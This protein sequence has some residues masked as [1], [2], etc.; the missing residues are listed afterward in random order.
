MFLLSIV[1]FIISKILKKKACKIQNTN[2]IQRGK[3]TYKDLD[4]PGKVF[5]S[6]KYKIAGKPDYIVKQKN[7]F[8]PVELKSTNSTEPRQNHILQLAAYCQLI[9]EKYG[10]FV[11][12]GIL[13]YN[14]TQQYS[15]PFDPKTRFELESTIKEMRN[16]LKTGK[17]ALNHDQMNRCMNCSMQKYCDNKIC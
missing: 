2:K 16:V 12:Y 13:V 1:F 8:I 7:K 9:E 4:A 3:I 6:K 14:N 5:F 10:C 17:I 15:I 11:P